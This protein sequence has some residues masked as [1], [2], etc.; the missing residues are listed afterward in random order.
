MQVGTGLDEQLHA[1]EPLRINRQPL[2]FSNPQPTAF[3]SHTLDVSAPG[4]MLQ[5]PATL[6]QSNEPSIELTGQQECFSGLFST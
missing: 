1:L 5:S 3:P 4:T 2:A 6:T